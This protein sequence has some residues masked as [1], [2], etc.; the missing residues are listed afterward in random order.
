LFAVERGRVRGIRIA[1][2][3]HVII[4]LVGALA[5][6]LGLGFLF[7]VVMAGRR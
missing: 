1:G 6:A 3:R 4:V 7:G 5:V 2:S